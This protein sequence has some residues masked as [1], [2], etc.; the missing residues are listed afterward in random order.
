V[1]AVDIIAAEDVGADAI[2][3]G[4]DVEVEGICEV[5]LAGAGVSSDDSADAPAAAVAGTSDC[6][7]GW[8]DMVALGS[9]SLT[10]PS[11][12]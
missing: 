12:R 1:G 6:A 11:A 9:L 4:A 8:S 7:G 3:A 2:G 10:L 5:S